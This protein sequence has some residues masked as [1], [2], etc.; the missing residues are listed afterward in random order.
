MKKNLI[1]MVALLLSGVWV[2]CSEKEDLWLQEQGDIP[3]TAVATGVGST[4]AFSRLGYEDDKNGGVSVCWST[5]DAFYMENDGGAYAT[6]TIVSGTEDKTTANFAGFLSQPMTA[7]EAVTAYYPA[8]AYDAENK[9]FNVDLSTSVQDFADGA[10]MALLDSTYYMVGTGIYDASGNINV[11]FTGGTK[12][13]ML[14]FDMTIPAHTTDANIVEFQVISEDL[15]TVGTLSADGSIFVPDEYH[16]YHRQR[17]KLTNLKA[18]TSGE[19]TFSVY[20]NVLPVTLSHVMKLRVKL[21]D[22][23]VYWCDVD[24]L[25]GVSLTANHRYYVI[26]Q[27]FGKVG[28]DYSWYT[29]PDAESYTLKDEEDLR[30]FARIVNGTA[31]SISKD[32]FA[33]QTVYLGSNVSLIAD[34]IPIGHRN[35][36]SVIYF[37][38]TFEA[39]N[40][41]V[42][43][44]FLG[45][46]DVYSNNGAGEGFFGSID[47]AV[48]RDLTVKGCVVS[49][50]IKVGGIVGYS[51]G[52]SIIHNCR[53]E[54]DIISLYTIKHSNRGCYLGGIVGE[55]NNGMHISECSNSGHIRTEEDINGTIYAGGIVG[56]AS[57]NS[58]VACYN[59]GTITIEGTISPYLGG[60]AGMFSGCTI[61]ACYNLT[62]NINASGGRKYGIGYLNSNQN[63][64]YGCYTLSNASL[65]T[66]L[67]KKYNYILTQETK[68]G[69]EQMNSLNDAILTWNKTLS[70]SDAV[71]YCNY[72]YEK[73]EAHLIVKPGAPESITEPEQ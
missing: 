34:W 23:T 48:I 14:R 62:D 13:S 3:V 11:D 19:T 60:I 51:I 50:A 39:R 27:S 49:K 59:S 35:S 33:G 29:S 54:A 20:V 8:H 32:D 16:E 9:C 30:G 72:H 21:S 45:E 4:E 61:S 66:G 31:S 24:N 52:K 73:G 1:K 15:N 64:D 38:G 36:S 69:E 12:V 71:G 2:A 47:G 10:S 26:R 17:V 70:G 63:K 18:S 56:V 41:I 53:N 57:S 67:N 22:E 7:N 44:V 55:S 65:E 46:L 5:G 68:N 28:I 25:N 43:D 6:M 40:Y 42:G 58:F 37:K